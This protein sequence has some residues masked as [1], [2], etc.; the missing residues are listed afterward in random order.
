MEKGV[1]GIAAD[2]VKCDKKYEQIVLIYL[3]EQLIV[4][5]MDTAIVLARL[6]SYSFRI[7]TLEGDIINPSG[8]IIWWF[9]S[10]KNQ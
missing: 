10:N 5:N 8:A 9:Y 1:I 7:V 4:E 2:L 3:E 6:N